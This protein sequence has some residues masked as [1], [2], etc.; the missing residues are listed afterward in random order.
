[1]LDYIAENT[2]IREDNTENLLSSWE[3]LQDYQE[4]QTE[5][6][7]GYEQQLLNAAGSNSYVKLRDDISGAT[8]DYTKAA[9]KASTDITVDNIKSTFDQAQDILDTILEYY[10]KRKA[11]GATAD[12]LNTIIES[13]SEQTEIVNDLS[14]SYVSAL[15]SYTDFV[16]ELAEREM[17]QYSDRN[18]WQEKINDGLE[19][20]L[21]KT[22]DIAEKSS[23]IS[24][25]IDNNN[26]QIEIYKDE[27]EKAHQGVLD[28]YDDETYAPIFEKYDLESWFDAEGNESAQFKTDLNEMSITHPEFVQI[29]QEVF[30]QVQAY[31]QAWYEAEEGIADCEDEIYELNQTQS[32]LRVD[33][34][35]EMLD[36]LNDIE[37]IRLNRQEAIISAMETQNSLSES[38]RSTMADVTEELDANKHLSEWLD[39]DTRALLFN[40]EDYA[41]ISK[42]IKSI[43]RDSDDL[44]ANY[45]AQLATLTE[46]TWY[47][48]EA[49]TAEYERQNEQLNERLE[50]AQQELELA[51]KRTEYEN[52]AKERNTR[53]IMGGRSVQV[54]DPDTMYDLA[55]ELSNLESEYKN[56][57]ITQ[58]ENE[59]V[60]EQE[61]LSDT[62]SQ[63]ISAREKMI[64]L[65]DG[66]TDL[67]KALFANS[68]P[69]LE[70][71][72]TAIALL[73]ATDIPWLNQNMMN[74]RNDISD[75][76]DEEREV[77]Y[78]LTVDYD[79]LHDT[80][81]KLFADGIIPSYYADMLNAWAETTH[82]TK[83]FSDVNTAQYP[84]TEEYGGKLGTPAFGQNYGSTTQSIQEQGAY[85]SDYAAKLDALIQKR[86]NQGGWLSKSD[87][88]TAQWLETMRNRK[89]FNNGL[90]YAQ[91][92]DFGG[93]TFGTD[94]NDFS[95]SA[96]DLQ[97]FCQENG[98]LTDK[99]QQ[100][101]DLLNTYSE[102]E[103]T[104]IND[105]LST[106]VDVSNM[107][108]TIHNDLV[109]ALAP[110]INSISKTAIVSDK[111][112]NA[113]IGDIASANLVN[114]YATGTKSAS[115]GIAVTDEEGYEWKL[116][117]IQNGNYT[118][119]GSGDMVFSKSATDNLWAFANNPTG[120]FSEQLKSLTA[121]LTSGLPLIQNHTDVQTTEIHNHFT[122]D[123]IFTETIDNASDFVAD[124]T[125][126]ASD[127][128]DIT[129]N[130]R[131]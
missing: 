36:R 83:A 53:I 89:I 63:E 70:E 101:I 27:Q 56:T 92:S 39:D 5:L 131:R 57:Q 95:Q 6:F 108:G 59:A 41:A 16:T 96:I 75:M 129:K 43:Q 105:L 49:I 123:N 111:D 82:N 124:L 86:N 62:I 99:E 94:L 117:Q 115:A 76:T 46:T 74:Y 58:S 29:M 14:D 80:I 23:I 54:A 13:Y 11:E 98:G 35:T 68:L 72:T 104:R 110:L 47:E 122:G 7:R 8:I 65:I 18:S 91:T 73:S 1:M 66:M 120:Y 84:Q 88:A 121:D 112:N 51:K 12:E 48:E 130:M 106:G 60:R 31:K 40:D 81:D 30:N 25:L 67:E 34:Y 22:D 42:E 17:Q 109:N 2:E 126:M 15:Q 107:L 52:T 125:R 61:R 55:K 21:E 4:K 79:A 113:N 71:T 45:Q 127:R 103:E 69:L 87:L 37:T 50:N 118:A 20:Q 44:F 78:N 116:K 32:D 100:L 33:A 64:E 19:R 119:L 28:L 10:R 114:H 90:D 38:L 3:K 9:I 102:Q 77:G 128:N 26:N 93:L 97:A 85:I 24:D